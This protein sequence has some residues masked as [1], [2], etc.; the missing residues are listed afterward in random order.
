MTARY[1]TS[2]T[3][4]Q[5][6]LH[7]QRLTS[8]DFYADWCGPCHAMGPVVDELADNLKG[9]VNVVKVKVDESPKLARQYGVQSIPNF[10][11]GA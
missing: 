10:H 5:E 4:E 11:R 9:H 2:E 1:I 3:F 6:V 8:V 7:S